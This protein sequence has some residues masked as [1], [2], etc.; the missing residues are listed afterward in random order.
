MDKAIY[1]INDTMRHKAEVLKCGSNL[2]SNYKKQDNSFINIIFDIIDGKIVMDKNNS[3]STYEVLVFNTG[4]EISKIRNNYNLSNNEI[5][6]LVLRGLYKSLNDHDCSKVYSNIPTDINGGLY[7]LRLDYNKK[8]YTDSNEYNLYK[9]A[10]YAMKSLEFG[11]PAYNKIRPALDEGFKLHS[12]VNPHHPEF[13]RDGIWDMDLFS[14]MEMVIDWCAAAV[15][16]GFIFKMSSVDS[17][18]T[19]FKMDKSIVNII[20]INIPLIITNLNMIHYD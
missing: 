20:K 16:R 1:H 11:S 10:V 12:E 4:H 2:L 17:H 13:Y 3:T 18:A 19:R 15:A 8:V 5:K 7:K 6:E 14:I 9:D